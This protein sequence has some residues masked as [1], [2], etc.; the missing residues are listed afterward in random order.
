MLISRRNIV[1]V[2]PHLVSYLLC[3]LGGNHDGALKS[4]LLHVLVAADVPEDPG[5]LAAKLLHDD[6]VQHGLGDG[7]Q[8]LIDIDLV[9]PC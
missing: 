4:S 6:V 2:T 1:L 8:D 7:H 5:R 9:L 3:L